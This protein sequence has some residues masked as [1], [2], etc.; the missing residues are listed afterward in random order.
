MGLFKKSIIGLE[1]DSKEIRTV[2]ISGSKKIR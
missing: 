2:E 1:M